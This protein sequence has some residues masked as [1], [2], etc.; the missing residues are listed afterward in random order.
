MVAYS[1][2]LAEYWFLIITPF[3]VLALLAGIGSYRKRKKET[4]DWLKG[5]IRNKRSD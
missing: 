3:V 1:Q 2:R 5:D 4:D